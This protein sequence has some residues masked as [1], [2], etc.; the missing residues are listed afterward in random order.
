M[1]DRLNATVIGQVEK[2][3][4]KANK[5]VFFLIDE[6]F[7]VVNSKLTKID[8]RG[9]VHLEELF[10]DRGLIGK[11]EADGFGIVWEERDE[12]DEFSDGLM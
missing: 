1:S 12:S 8:S 7:D 6:R 4:I 10:W 3:V 9:G 5:K 11:E 2:S